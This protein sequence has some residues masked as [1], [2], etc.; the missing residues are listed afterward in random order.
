M[1][2]TIR[3]FLS[4][5]FKDMDIER[6]AL[7]NIVLPMLNERF[8]SVQYQVEMVDLRHSIETDKNED[9]E[10]RER[11]I[12]NICMDEIESCKPFFLGLVGHRYGWIPDNTERLSP[13]IF[14]NVPDDFPIDKEHL[15]VTVF[16]FINGMLSTQSVSAR[17]NVLVLLRNED[18][19]AGMDTATRADYIDTGDSK[20]YVQAL[21]RYLIERRNDYP[22]TEYTLRQHDTTADDRLKWSEQVYLE[23]ERQLSEYINTT[24]ETTTDTLLQEEAFVHSRIADFVGREADIAHCLA[25]VQAG[26]GVHIN[27][28]DNGVGQSALVCK[29]YDILRQDESRFCLFHS[30]EAYSEGVYFETPLYDWCFLMCLELVEGLETLNENKKDFLLLRDYFYHLMGRIRTELGKK[31]TICFD[32]VGEMKDNVRLRFPFVDLIETVRMPS[33]YDT[34]NDNYVLNSLNMEERSLVARHLRSRPRQALL[35]RDCSGNVLWLTMAVTIANSLNKLDYMKIR[36]TDNDQ[37][38]SIDDHIISIIGDMPAD[39]SNLLLFWISRLEDIFGHRLVYDFMYCLAFGNGLTDNDLSHILNMSPVE[40]ALVR[41]AIGKNIIIEIAKGY[42][43]LVEVMK[44]GFLDHGL[45]NYPDVIWRFCDYVLG[46]PH[47]SLTWQG[48]AVLAS[49][50]RCDVDTAMTIFSD[51]NQM[52]DGSHY[53]YIYNTFYALIR[54]HAP[55]V[56][57]TMRAIIEKAEP[58][59]EFFVGLSHW[60]EAATAQNQHMLT[61]ELLRYPYDTFYEKAINSTIDEGMAMAMI[62][63][64]DRLSASVVH[65]EDGEE[66]WQ[67]WIEQVKALADKYYRNTPEWNE[68]MFLILLDMEQGF[69]YLHERWDLLVKMFF[70]MMNEELQLAEDTRSCHLARLLADSATLGAKYANNFDVGGMALMAINNFRRAFAQE[71]TTSNRRFALGELM[72]N[73]V[74]MLQLTSYMDKDEV[75]T[76]LDKAWEAYSVA[77]HPAYEALLTEHNMVLAAELMSNITEVVGPRDAQKAMDI[78]DSF[79]HRMVGQIYDDELYR[80]SSEEDRSERRHRNYTFMQNDIINHVGNVDGTTSSLTMAY[81]W[82]YVARLR[83]MLLFDRNDDITSMFPMD[84][85]QE[86]NA[87]MSLMPLTNADVYNHSLSNSAVLCELFFLLMLYE[88]M[89]GYRHPDSARYY[90]QQY[91]VFAEKEAVYYRSHNMK[92]MMHVEKMGK[93]IEQL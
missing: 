64:F 34:D 70:P 76:L 82:G 18:S 61:M 36:S 72:E 77:I 22:L 19:Y 71:K 33:E 85:Q 1:W 58:S 62:R 17:N 21:R 67:Q 11:L 14:E 43:V 74:F 5:T 48:N 28:H 13:S 63:L 9:A 37:E 46:L 8:A 38:D 51:K 79:F 57:A 47:D 60:L 66:L 56:R 90:L 45:Q 81:A 12:F 49:L 54:F 25:M 44:K 41:Q 80:K 91:E 40:V 35:A 3:I 15:S 4:S 20:E 26:K 16:E 92:K 59:P 30:T 24:A 2:K 50:F 55:L 84:M 93:E 73:I 78:A 52:Y 88:Q 23:L 42:H 89:T 86:I 69:K 32:N 65:I 75:N 7:K 27:Q 68:L 83:I 29:L 39:Y 6:D 31:V 53:S 10:Q 87:L